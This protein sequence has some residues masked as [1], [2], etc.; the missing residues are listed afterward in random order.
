LGK[1]K[2]RFRIDKEELRETT[3]T[4][5]DRVATGDVSGWGHFHP[6]EML[7]ML[8]EA[9]DDLIKRRALNPPNRSF[10]GQTRKSRALVRGLVLPFFQTFGELPSA[11]V[12]GVFGS[13]VNELLSALCEPEVGQDALRT[14][15]SEQIPGF[16]R[17]RGPKP[18]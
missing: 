6:D 3:F 14:I 15:I 7:S 18:L 16:E 10:P 5:A 13:I 9:V 2:L 12:E 17:M 1:N 8:D 11:A 4:E